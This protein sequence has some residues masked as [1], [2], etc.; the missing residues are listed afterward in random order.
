ME[1]R[2]EAHGGSVPV[3]VLTDEVVARFPDISAHSVE[4]Y[5]SSWA[6]VVR[7]GMVRRRRRGDRWPQI[8]PLNTARGAYR[9][10]DNEV[11]IEISVDAEL[12]RGSGRHVARAVAAAAGVRPGKCRTFAGPTGSLTLRWDLVDTRGPDLGSLRAHAAAVDATTGDHLVLALRRRGRALLSVSRLR[13]SDDPASQLQTLLGRPIED[14]AA[15]FAEALDCHP[16]DVAAILR[17][18]GDLYWARLIE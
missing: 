7:D 4:A 14:A 9:L 2:I 3:G 5:L 11:R 17:A 8:A 6:F 1:E 10:S 12:L 16:D 13:R 15:A 18:R